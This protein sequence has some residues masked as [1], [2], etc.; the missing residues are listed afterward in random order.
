M[1]GYYLYIDASND[2]HDGYP[3]EVA[4]IKTPAIYG[5][6]CVTFYYHSYGYDT[7][8][9]IVYEYKE[10]GEKRVI[11]SRDHVHG[12]SAWVSG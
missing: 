10:G 12:K 11:F 7:K 8:D 9:L 2:H 4:S 5:A 1:A 3:Q 6:Q